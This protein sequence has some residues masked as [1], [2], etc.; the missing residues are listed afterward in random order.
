[1]ARNKLQLVAVYWVD[2][3]HNNGWIA[4]DRLDDKEKCGIAVGFLARKTK[5]FVTLSHQYNIGDW[6]GEF[7]IPRGMVRKIVVIRE[8]RKD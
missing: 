3:D 7:R 6:L 1:M 4:D 2:A 8:Y 5:K